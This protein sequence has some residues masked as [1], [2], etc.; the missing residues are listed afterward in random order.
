MSLR[1][2]TWPPGRVQV[3]THSRACR[4]NAWNC[5]DMDDHGFCGVL[6]WQDGLKCGIRSVERRTTVLRNAGRKRF[7]LHQ[8]DRQRFTIN[9]PASLEAQQT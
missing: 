5:H 9:T 1:G 7:G 8:H 3:T 2:P 4:Q 6:N